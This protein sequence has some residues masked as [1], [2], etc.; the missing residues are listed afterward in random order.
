MSVGEP[1]PVA[2]ADEAP[3]ADIGEATLLGDLLAAGSGVALVAAYAPFEVFPLAFLAPALLFRLWLDVT[4]GRAAWRG[5]LFGLGFFGAGVY[6]VTISIHHYG[7]APLPLSIAAML[8]LVAFLALYPA[9]LGWLGQ[10]LA[11]RR[12]ALMLLWVLPLGWVLFEWVRSWLLTGF[13]WLE[14]GSSQV[15]A[16]LGAWAPVAGVYGVGLAVAFTAGALAAILQGGWAARAFAV[17]LIAALWAGAFQLDKLEWGRASGEPFRASLVQGNI[18][19][20]LKWR[21]DQRNATLE[22]YVNLTLQAIEGEP[23]SRVVVWPETAIP[24]FYDEVA[25][26]F[27]PALQ[28]RLRGTGAALVTGI[29]V[30]ERDDWQVYNAVMALND[31]IGFYYKR[32]LV[33]FG[34]YVPL[35]S[36]LGR[37]LEIMPLPVADFSAGP[38]DQP[39]LRV[40]G[41]GVGASVCYEVAFAREIRRALPG[42]A[43]LVNVSNDGWFGDSLAPHQHLQ[44][45]QLRA[46]E[47]GRY[48][49]RATNT[50]ITAVIDPRGRIVARAPQ[51][52]TAVIHADI[53]PRSGATPYVRFGDWPVVAFTF[54]GLLMVMATKRSK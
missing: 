20:E 28:E 35:R 10:R 30:L 2:A 17:V 9:V 7:H 13:P 42:A 41:Q 16:P 5:Y 40:H 27:I 14:L 31:D 39:L 8:T 22:R 11:G 26:G 36:I 15:A 12:P 33:P 49:L 44:M 24:A 47:T 53:T 18:A 37:L 38:V 21:P 29:P 51:F 45:A 19:Q 32:H 48:L 3:K 25:D 1:Q 46:R 54:L 23:A 43:W 6:W 34:E 52:Q 50:G 4:P